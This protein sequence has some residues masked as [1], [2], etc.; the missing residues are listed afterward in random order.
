VAAA[1]EVQVKVENGLA[2]A[3]AI[4]ED[5]AIAG[6]KVTLRG[7][8][9]GDKLQFAEK[10]GIAL[11]RFVERGEMFARTD[12]DVCGGLRAD[13]FEGE[14]VVIFVDELRGDLF[15]ADF[16]EEAVGVHGWVTSE[17][18]ELIYIEMD[19]G[20]FAGFEAKKAS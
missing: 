12:Q 9:R 20:A 15:C 14:D 13:V 4:V 2:G 1:K 8:F 19:F 16:A 5:G 18:Q 7:E 11:V 17:M 10:G 3:G 6:E